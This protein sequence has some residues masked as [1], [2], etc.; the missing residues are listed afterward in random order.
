[1]LRKLGDDCIFEPEKLA[2][3]QRAFDQICLNHRYKK[4]SRDCEDLAHRLLSIYKSGV[5]NEALLKAA[6]KRL[7]GGK[8]VDMGNEEEVR[9]AIRDHFESLQAVSEPGAIMVSLLGVT[10]IIHR[11]FALWEFDDITRLVEQEAAKQAF[12]AL[13]D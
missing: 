6:A 13:V 4:E 10:G 8:G 7:S 1:M 11:Q 2:R 3:M 9:Q 12:V 5:Q